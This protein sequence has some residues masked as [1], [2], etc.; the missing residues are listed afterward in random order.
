MAPRHPHAPTHVPERGPGCQAPQGHPQGHPSRTVSLLGDPPECPQ[1]ECCRVPLRWT[2]GSRCRVPVHELRGPQPWTPPPMPS[3]SPALQVPPPH[4]LHRVPAVTEVRLVR[5][6]HLAHI[7]DG[8]TQTDPQGFCSLSGL[9]LWA[10]ESPETE[11]DAKLTVESADGR[12]GSFDPRG[13]PCPAPT[14]RH[15]L[16]P[17]SNVASST[18]PFLPSPEVTL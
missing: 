1:A 7:R 18:R 4:N 12:S 3:P 6:L 10:S 13:D 16:L 17:D 2:T 9:A 11:K 8:H 14:W 5:L 15:H